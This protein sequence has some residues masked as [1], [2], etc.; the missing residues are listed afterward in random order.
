MVAKSPLS[1]GLGRS[2]AGGWWGPELKA[3]GFDGIILTGRAPEPVYLWIHDGEVEIRPA[4]DLWDKTTGE[5]QDAILEQTG[6]RRARVLQCGPAAFRGVRFAALTNELRHWNGRCGM[7]AVLA[8]KNVRAIAVRGTGKVRMVDEDRAREILRQLRTSYDRNQSTMHLHG[9]SRGV[10][11]LNQDGIF[12]TRNFRDGQFDQADNISGPTMSATILVGRGTCY[13]C[14]V[15]CKREVEVPSLGVDP[16][17][18]GP[19]YETIGSLGSLCGIGSLEHVALGN[20]LCGQYGLDTISTG[21]AIAFAMECY[22]NGLLTNADTGGL[23]LRFGNAE[24]MLEMIHRIGRREGL[25]DLLAEGVARAAE[26][27]PGSQRYAMHVKGQEVPLHEPRGKKGLALSYALS[28]TGADHMEAP[29]D[30]FLETIGIQGTDLA[31][32]GLYE[33]LDR[34]DFSFRKVRAYYTLQL[35]W[36]TYNVIGMCTFAATPTGPIKLPQLVDFYSAVTG[37]STSLWEMLRLAQRA[38]TM[39]RVFNL[40]EGLGPEDDRLP[41]RFFEP[42]GN[43]PLQGEKM[44]PAQFDDAR[45]LFYELSGWDPQTGAPTRARLIELGLEWLL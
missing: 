16:K 29:H 27:I 9:T 26:R 13:A 20:Q 28:P 39:Y 33:P 5:V 22:E 17:Y 8:S 40:R 21:V 41:Q 6:E 14:A 45:R 34:M 12:P 35:L 42:L 38:S 31:P 23:E 25:G 43:G 32:L 2:E 3:A 1:L 24:A 4:Q 10:P 30:P 11:G 15:A 37:W 44:D 36:G 19:E 18:G 7:G